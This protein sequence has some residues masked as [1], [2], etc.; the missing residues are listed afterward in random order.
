MYPD[1]NYPIPQTKSE[2]N[3]ALARIQNQLPTSGQN[4]ADLNGLHALVDAMPDE[5]QVPPNA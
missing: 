1:P 2:L 3:A 5:N 4:A